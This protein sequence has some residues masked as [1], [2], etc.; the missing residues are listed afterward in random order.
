M[1]RL[2]GDV[3]KEGKVWH[4]F[5]YSLQVWVIDGRVQPCYHPTG[6]SEISP[7]AGHCNARKYRNQ[8]LSSIPG[9]EERTD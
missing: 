7:P 8:L 4:G 1:S 6:C 5:D 2:S 9:H 3:I